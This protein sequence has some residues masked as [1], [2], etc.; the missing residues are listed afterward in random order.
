L[1]TFPRRRVDLL[2]ALDQ[3]LDAERLELVAREERVEVVDVG[4]VVL[5]VVE[6]EGLR[7]D[8]RRERVLRVGQVGQLVGHGGV[9]RSWVPV[10]G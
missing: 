2:D 9:L 8:V 5:A 3:L 4:V 6:A 10:G 1:N 7:R